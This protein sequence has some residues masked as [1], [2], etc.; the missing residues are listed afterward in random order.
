LAQ[1]RCLFVTAVPTQDNKGLIGADEL[2]KM[3]NQALLILLSRA[4]LVDMDAVIE[5]VKAR[6]IRAAID[7]FDP[8]P[9]AA[10]DPIRGMEGLILSPH[11][12]A[13][14]P[15][16]RQLIGEMVLQDMAARFAGNPERV[17]LRADRAKM[18]SLFGMGD[19]AKVGDM[20]VKRE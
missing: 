9:V 16:G 20:A 1:S 14:V 11:R 18:A 17:L 5:A 12:A 13:A 3:P 7:V 15:G 2:S 10:N 19:G 8:E 6:K 4:H